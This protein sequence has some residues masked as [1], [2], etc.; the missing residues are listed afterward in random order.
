MNRGKRLIA[1]G[2]VTGEHPHAQQ[3]VLAIPLAQSFQA[4]TE[5]A[6]L[7]GQ[8]GRTYLTCWIDHKVKKSVPK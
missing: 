5:R 7:L 8:A 4:D 1:A 6:E 3:G 2:D